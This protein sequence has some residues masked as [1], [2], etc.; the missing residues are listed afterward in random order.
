MTTHGNTR[1]MSRRRTSTSFSGG[2]VVRASKR[3]EGTATLSK[4]KVYES[5]LCDVDD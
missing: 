1:S 4:F 2:G 3:G 5:I